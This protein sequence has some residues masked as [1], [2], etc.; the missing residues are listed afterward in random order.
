MVKSTGNRND[1]AMTYLS[2]GAVKIRLRE[3]ADADK[4][5]KEAL[6]VALETGS[7]VWKRECYFYFSELDSLRGNFKSALD[8][9]KMYVACND[10]LVNEE[11][12]KK[13]VQAEM[14]YEFDKKE[15][16]AKLE[17]E[18]K[19]AVAAA[20]ARR[21]RIILFTISGFGLLVMGFALFA[22]RSFLQKKKAN[23]EISR[24]KELIEE[25]Q[26]EILDSIYYARRIQTCLLPREKYIERCLKEKAGV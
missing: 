8:H 26:K 5:L 20:D 14:Q 17:Q 2:L 24:Q 4:F 19:D 21:Q 25:K 9:Y 16:A 3:L 15:A 18:K 11:T 1:L 6:V 7:K 22:W 13:T 12:T 23:L 10:S